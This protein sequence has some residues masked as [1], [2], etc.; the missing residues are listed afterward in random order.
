[1][2]TTMSSGSFGSDGFL[3]AASCGQQ[4][5]PEDDRDRKRISGVCGL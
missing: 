5:W 1:M 2:N 3:E 4:I